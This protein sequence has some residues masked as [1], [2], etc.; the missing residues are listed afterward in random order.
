MYQAATTFSK[1]LPVCEMTSLKFSKFNFYAATS[2]IYAQ[3]VPVSIGFYSAYLTYKQLFESTS[4][5]PRM[6]S[7]KFS[8]FNFYAATS[9]IYAQFVPVSRG[10]YSAYLTY[11][12]LFEST[13][14][15][16]EWRH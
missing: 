3:F 1:I 13:S 16:R 4:I 2:N 8:K 12:Q 15:M 6:T 10:L 7:L 9:N 5:M 14:V 11:K